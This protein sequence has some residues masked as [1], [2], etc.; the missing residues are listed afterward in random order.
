MHLVMFDI[1]VRLDPNF[2][3]AW[4]MLVRLNSLWYFWLEAKPSLRAAAQKSLETA[5][6]LRP[7]LPEVQLAQAFYQYFILRDLE[8]CPSEF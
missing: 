8:G 1:A 2:A 3:M 7:D 5:M 4:A 6:R